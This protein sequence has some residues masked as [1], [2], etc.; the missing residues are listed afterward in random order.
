MQTR[1]SVFPLAEEVA[2]RPAPFLFRFHRGLRFALATALSCMP[3]MLAT[4][5]TTIGTS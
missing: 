5:I 2:V 4:T 1:G 3:L